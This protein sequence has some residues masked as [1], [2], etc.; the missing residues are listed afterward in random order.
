MDKIDY[1]RKKA[2][3]NKEDRV[4]GEPS[5]ERRKNTYSVQKPKLRR[6]SVKYSNHESKGSPGHYR[7]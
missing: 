6:A 2:K 3:F 7:A 1:H 5:W 4:I